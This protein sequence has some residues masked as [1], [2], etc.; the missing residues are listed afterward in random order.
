MRVSSILTTPEGDGFFDAAAKWSERKAASSRTL[1]AGKLKS[2]CGGATSDGL[3]VGDRML[4]KSSK[5][6]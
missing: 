5:P 2:P 3:L 4:R 1:N 6:R